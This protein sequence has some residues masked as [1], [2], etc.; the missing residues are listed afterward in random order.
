MTPRKPRVQITADSFQNFRARLGVGTDNVASGGDYGFNFITRNR[1]RLEAAYRGSWIV[2]RVVDAPA[3]DMTRAGFDIEAG[4][5]PDALSEIQK[6]WTDMCV[7]DALRDAIRWGRLYGGAAAVV[8]IDG[9][10]PS[11]PLDVDSI[12]RGQFKGLLAMDRWML[13]PSMSE[14]ITD[15]GPDFGK[16]EFYDYFGGYAMPVRGGQMRFHH[17]RIIRFEGDPLP[18]LQRL[19]EMSWG[20]SVVEQ[21]YDRLLAFD[22]ATQGASQLVYKAHLRT[23]KVHDLRELISNGGVMYEAFLQQMQTIR[24]LQTNEGL[25]VIDAEDEMEYHINSAISGIAGALDK[26]GEQLSGAC[27][28]PLVI[29]F[30]QS[31]QGFSTGETDVRNYYDRIAT[32][33]KSFL[34]K[35][36]SRLVDI[37]HRSFFGKPMER[38]AAITFKP[39]WQLS[40]KERADAAVA[41]TGAVV[42]AHDAGIT[43]QRTSLMELRQSADITG[44][45]SNISDE[46]IAAADEEPPAPETEGM[47]G[48]PG[49][50]GQPPSTQ[51]PGAQPPQDSGDSPPLN[52]PHAPPT[53]R[54]GKPR[55]QPLSPPGTAPLRAPGI[56]ANVNINLPDDGTPYQV[57]RS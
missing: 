19:Q 14:L 50:E 51:P 49:A 8:M 28:I 21:L 27:G 26:F 52:A 29:L 23:Y 11:T 39:L 20:A 30:G 31:P 55:V 33:Q 44:I 56:P 53:Q 32:D 10:D 57:N 40:D 41:I 42:Q 43:S 1:T 36:V 18:Q 47:P 6:H 22:S 38:D 15:F 25:T 13:F 24:Q 9:Q 34:H 37:L 3:N 54:T 5:D 35:P 48:M 4:I 16:P 17:S 7:W 2:R 45:W 12:R 46:D